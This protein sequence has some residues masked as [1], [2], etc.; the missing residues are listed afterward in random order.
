MCLF[1]RG[2]SF[3]WK[4]F[5][6]PGLSDPLPPAISPKPWFNPRFQR[7][8]RLYRVKSIIKSLPCT[9]FALS[10]GLLFPCSCPAQFSPC[11][12]WWNQFSC[13]LLYCFHPLTHPRVF[14]KLPVTAGGKKPK[15]PIR[16]LT[17]WPCA[18]PACSQM[19][20]VLP[21]RA[22]GGTKPC[23]ASLPGALPAFGAAA[24]L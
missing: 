10:P 6:T 16:E 14:V 7:A 22:P 21:Q 2:K 1:L 13:A 24:A 20:A 12:F 11:T 19:G 15:L 23:L 17:Q 9:A 3:L 5:P 8:L 4:L 18:S